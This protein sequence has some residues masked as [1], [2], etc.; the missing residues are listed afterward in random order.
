MRRSARG[1]IP[2]LLLTCLAK[3]RPGI[4]V[5]LRRCWHGFPSTALTGLPHEDEERCPAPATDADFICSE[6]SDLAIARVWFEGLPDY[7]SLGGSVQRT[8]GLEAGGDVRATDL[9]LFLLRAETSRISVQAGRSSRPS[10]SAVAT[11]G[12]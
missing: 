5:E 4:V 11:A 8:L 1:G 2:L 7:S 12:D 9:L 10:R 6:S 3:S